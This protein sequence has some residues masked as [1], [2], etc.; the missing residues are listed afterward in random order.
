MPSS[1]Q[2]HI[3]IDMSPIPSGARQSDATGASPRQWAG[4]NG[5][6]RGAGRAPVTPFVFLHGLTFD[7]RMWGP[8]LDA[9]LAGHRAI[10]FDLTGHGDSEVLPQNGLAAVAEAVHAAVLDA[11]LDA[12]VVVGHSIAGRLATI[13]TAAHPA[14]AVVSVDAPVRLEAF[15]QVLRS[16]R[17]QLAGGRLWR[18]LGDLPGQLAYGTAAGRSQ[19][20]PARGRP[21]PETTPCGNSY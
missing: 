4:L 11:G 14:A 1:A 6:A 18:G 2:E 5:R 17:P 21:P 8:V 16:L 19:C 3:L 20:A 10:A 7:R 15:A 13:Y 9:L 12:P